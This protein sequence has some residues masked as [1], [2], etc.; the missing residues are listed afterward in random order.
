[1]FCY[2]NRGVFMPLLIIML[3]LMKHFAFILLAVI[4]Y[5]LIFLRLSKVWSMLYHA[6]VGGVQNKNSTL[7]FHLLVWLFFH[8]KICVHDFFLWSIKF[9]QQN[10]NQSELVVSNCQRNCM[11]KLKYRCLT[12]SKI[13]LPASIY[14]LK[15]NNKNLR[16]RCKICSKLTIK[17]SGRRHWRRYSAFIVNFEHISHLALVFLLFHWN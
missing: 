7:Y 12:G 17:T 9:P 8:H 15:V 14:M 1:M 11:K 10:I 2:D 16:T 5:H 4:W 13:Y 3:L 6:S